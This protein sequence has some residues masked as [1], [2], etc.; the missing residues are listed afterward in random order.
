MYRKMGITLLLGVAVAGSLAQRP[1]YAQACQDEETMVTD[2]QKSIGDLVAT[3]KK[4]S[5]QDFLRHYHRKNILSKLTLCPGIVDI[6]AECLTKAGSD[7]D[8]SKQQ[9]EQYKAKGEAYTKL[10]SKVVQYRDELKAA[11]PGKDSKALIEK[12]DLS[13]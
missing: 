5:L 8:A 3:V 4:E 12:F 9:K 2:Y 6:A 10:K 11:E 7:P 13:G 1:V